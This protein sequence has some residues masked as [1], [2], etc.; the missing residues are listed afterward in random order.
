MMG[1]L[2]NTRRVNKPVEKWFNNGR[3]VER[4]FNQDRY[5][6]KPLRRRLQ[7]NSHG[8]QQ[9]PLHEIDD[10][11]AAANNPNNLMF[12]SHCRHQVALCSGLARA[13]YVVK[14]A[15]YDDH[16]FDV[17]RSIYLGHCK[18][19]NQYGFSEIGYMDERGQYRVDLVEFPNVIHIGNLRKAVR[20]LD[21]Q[22]Y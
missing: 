1:V 16:F 13:K 18:P 20:L 2:S 6:V 9:K 14:N 17:D 12:V 15:G 10:H 8:Y 19:M 22:D 21:K 3:P 5:A 11:R 7:D 4:D